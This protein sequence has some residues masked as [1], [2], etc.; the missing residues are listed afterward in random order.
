MEIGTTGDSWR[1]EATEE[2]REGRGGA[3]V[4]WLIRPNWIRICPPSLVLEVN[5]K[6]LECRHNGDGASSSP[7]LFCASYEPLPSSSSFSTIPSSVSAGDKRA[8]PLPRRNER[9]RRTLWKGWQLKPS[10]IIV[11]FNYTTLCGSRANDL[12]DTGLARYFSRDPV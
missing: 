12:P 9:E 3:M 10:T 5:V 7:R 1:D 4:I 11:P 6:G 2:S 8:V